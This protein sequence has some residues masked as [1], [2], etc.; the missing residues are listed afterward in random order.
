MPGLTAQGPREEPTSEGTQGVQGGSW[1]QDEG[2][3]QHQGSTLG[4]S[5]HSLALP[6]PF[7]ELLSPSELHFHIRWSE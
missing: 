5:P 6:G 2:G 1:G 3:L 7:P 4:L